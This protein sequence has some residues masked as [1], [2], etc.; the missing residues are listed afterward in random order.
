MSKH[1]ALC[2]DLLHPVH[3]SVYNIVSSGLA[4]A[5]LLFQRCMMCNILSPSDVVLLNNSYTSLFISQAL[6]T[7]CWSVLKAKRRL[8]MVSYYK[9]YKASELSSG[10]IQIYLQSEL[11]V[12]NEIKNLLKRRDL[13]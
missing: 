5:A 3:V 12:Y 10:F 6:A 13:K 8:L 2:P 7:A 11:S 4:F 9:T 1:L